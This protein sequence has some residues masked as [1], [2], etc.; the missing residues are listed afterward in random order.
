[1]ISYSVGGQPQGIAAGPDGAL[2]F[3]NRGEPDSIG[4]ITTSG[5]VTSYTGP[6]VD[7]PT[8]IAA[9]PDGGMW[10]TNTGN[11]TIGRIQAGQGL[12]R[13]A[14]LPVT[15]LGSSRADGLAGTPTHD[16]ILGGSGND[17]ISAAGGRDRAC[18]GTGND[19]VAG[20]AGSDTLLGQAG[21]D[22]LLGGP[23]RD[24]LRGGPG[25]DRLSGGLG[26]DHIF[27]GPGDDRITP[28]R[29]RDHVDAG[30]GNDRIFSRDSQRDVI[31]CGRGHDVALVDRID[32][33]RRCETVIRAH[34]PRRRPAPRGGLG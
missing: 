31:D 19:R 17:R 7:S 32:R 30:P 34:A 3:A 27:G 21:N 2:W 12:G 5:T 16:V 20:G 22:T 9:G 13:C 1:M 8:G 15:I 29:G 14:G 6:G 25:N 18:A 4:R 23:G 24:L 11:D 10:F 26:N 33:T 28:G